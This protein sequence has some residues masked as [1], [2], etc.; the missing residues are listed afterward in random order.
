MICLQSC[1]VYHRYCDIY[2]RSVR[3][4]TRRADRMLRDRLSCEPMST[5]INNYPWT[6]ML[7]TSN[8]FKRES[9]SDHRSNILDAYHNLYVFMCVC[10]SLYSRACVYLCVFA[11]VRN[12]WLWIGS[13]IHDSHTA[14]LARDYID[15]YS[16]FRHSVVH[17]NA[18][19]RRK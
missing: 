5:E 11:D 16:R 7:H 18:N 9:E 10:V 8:E 13:L 17:S 4:T 14:R 12:R 6:R 1:V 2:H 19:V 15:I 3:Q